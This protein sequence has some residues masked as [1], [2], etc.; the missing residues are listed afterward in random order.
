MGPDGDVMNGVTASSIALV[1][2]GGAAGSVLR[3]LVSMAGL[4]LFGAGFPWGTLAVNVIGS[5]VIGAL[6]AAGLD[7]QAR[8]LLITGLLGGF[9]TFS[10]FS[11]DTVSLWARAPALAVL[12]VAVSVGLSIAACAAGFWLLRR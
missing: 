3:Y 7:G 1:A 2:L 12:Y 11:I 9:T 4:A 8:Y 5:A 6:V 10:A